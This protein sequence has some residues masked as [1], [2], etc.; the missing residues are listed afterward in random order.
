MRGFAALLHVPEGKHDIESSA[1]ILFH[2]IWAWNTMH[3]LGILLQSLHKTWRSK[4][5]RDQYIVEDQ[6]FYSRSNQNGLLSVYSKHTN[7]AIV[8]TVDE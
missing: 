6:I 8:S 1:A 4:I 5:N 2:I 3:V 7:P